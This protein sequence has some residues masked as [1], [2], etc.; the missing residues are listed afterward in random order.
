MELIHAD[1]NL[2]EKQSLTD[3][4][5][6][7]LVAGL[8]NEYEDNDFELSI[9]VKIWDECKIE[10]GHFLYEPGAEWGGRVEL[11][12]HVDNMIKLGGPTWRGLL[13]RKIIK[14]LPGQ[15]Y[16]VINQVDANIAIGSLIGE[17]FGELI[18]STTDLAGV[19]VSGQFRYTNL[20]KAIH[21]MLAQYGLRLNV[22]FNGR[23][24]LS[25]QPIQ[26]L[27]DEE[28]LSQDYAAPIE[29]KQDESQA[30]N[31]VIAL[32]QGEMTARQVLEFYRDKSGNIS[33]T[34]LPAGFDDKQ[35][36][37][38]FPNAESI[39]ELEQSAREKLIETAPIQEISIDLSESQG[40][41][42]GDLVGGRDRVTGL[43]IVRPVSQ[44]IR[45]VD[46]TGESIEYKVGD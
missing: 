42:L 37:L 16:K 27:S 35:I 36:V 40:L 44:I 14:P 13:A 11:I 1:H 19:N 33:T 41:Q 2:I 18:K 25:A 5:Q 45:R 20:L 28:E 26:D 10:K 21:T 29:S 3:F 31:H 12:H 22:E 15:A 46:G 38:D 8:S 9:P 30:Y 34:P 4:Y 43:T 6:W 23:V 24:F 39:E 17:S 32:G 7:D